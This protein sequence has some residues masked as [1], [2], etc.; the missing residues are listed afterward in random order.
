MQLTRK[1]ARPRLSLI[2][3]IACSSLLSVVRPVR[4]G[5][6]FSSY[7]DF[8]ALQQTDLSTLQLKLSWFGP[9]SRDVL[10]LVSQNNT[11]VID[12]GPLAQFR[13]PNRDYSGDVY[14][15]PMEVRLSN[16]QLHA[17]LDSVGTISQV[18]DGANDTTAFFSFS[19]LQGD[20]DSTIG[21]EAIV[22]DSIGALVIAK[23]RSVVPEE[24]ARPIVEWA[25]PKFLPPSQPSDVT[26][27][28]VVVFSGVRLNRET[29]LFVSRAQL[30]NRSSHSLVAPI[31]VI[32][33]CA[34][35]IDPVG[36]DG[37]T[38]LVEPH[39]NP[40]FTF[41]S[42]GSLAPNHTVT[43]ICEFSNSDRQPLKL[44]TRVYSGPGTR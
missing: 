19:M 5:S 20:P 24:L 17:V 16:E 31:T 26:T 18:T 11:D 3:C 2:L 9:G 8:V 23:L 42:S 29:G 22:S 33:A 37:R 4:A 12:F 34:G 36:E 32:V 15:N 30:T 35:A 10:A 25:C 43:R 13:F 14:E 28:V 21:F 40:F 44:T 1:R 38:C 7:S 41:L 27:E 39:G 6:S